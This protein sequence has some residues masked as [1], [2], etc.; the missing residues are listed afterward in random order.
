MIHRVG[1]PGTLRARFDLAAA[2]QGFELDEAQRPVA[3]ELAALGAELRKHFHRPRGLYLHGPVGRGKSFLVNTFFAEAPVRGKLR[4]HFHDFFDRLHRTAARHRSSSGSSA[5][6][7][8]VAELLDG[9]RLVCFDE[10]HVH[11]PGDAG[12]ITH[13]LRALHAR[14]VTLVTTSNYPPDG[15]LPNPLYHHLFLPAIELIEA[16]QEVIALAGPTD[17]RTT[18]RQGRFAEG[19]WQ[20]PGSECKPPGG[21]EQSTLLING[22]NLRALAVRNRLAWFDFHELCATPTS[23]RDY[24][25]LAER[26]DTW[27]ISGV[28]R[29]ADCGPDARQRFANVVDVLCDKDITTHV[30]ADHSIAGTLADGTDVARTASRLALLRPIPLSQAASDAAV[31]ARS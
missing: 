25:A 23:T 29:L 10:F 11:D 16:H 26:F 15:L 18:N 13:L 20:W 8:A 22:R 27:V 3:D 12:L 7:A 24:L 28:P 6:D 21:E 14:R 19:T 4:V 9:C 2:Q 5:V 31:P 30:L 1:S 17:Y